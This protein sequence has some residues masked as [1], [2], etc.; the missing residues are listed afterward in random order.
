MT[1]KIQNV[2]A[3]DSLKKRMLRM[4]I[5]SP[6]HIHI[7]IQ[8]RTLIVWNVDFC[9]KQVHTYSIVAQR[10]KKKPTTTINES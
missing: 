8:C 7:H 5:Q 3:K 1:N 2:V 9:G 4:H 6:K 10:A